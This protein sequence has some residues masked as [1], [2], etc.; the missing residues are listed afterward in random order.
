L[1]FFHKFSEDEE[2]RILQALGL[3]INE[4][5]KCTLFN[6]K[7][8]FPIRGG[9]TEEEKENF[10]KSNRD[11]FVDC[12]YYDGKWKDYPMLISILFVP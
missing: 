9:I 12:P 7:S 5:K 6:D 1:Q 2:N 11:R 4:A 3:Q 8:K 10:C